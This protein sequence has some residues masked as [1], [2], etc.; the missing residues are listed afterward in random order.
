MKEES[1]CHILIAPVSK[2]RAIFPPFFP[3]D[4]VHALWQTKGNYI[5]S[6]R[7]AIKVPWISL[8]GICTV[9][10][11]IIKWQKDSK[12]YQCSLQLPQTRFRLNC[13]QYRRPSGAGSG[14]SESPPALGVPKDPN[15][16][17]SSSSWPT[18]PPGLIHTRW[19]DDAG[20]PTEN[21]LSDNPLSITHETGRV[22]PRD[23]NLSG[24]GEGDV[25]GG[26]IPNHLGLVGQLKPQVMQ[27][28]AVSTFRSG[29]HHPLCLSRG[30][31][32][33]LT[34]GNALTAGDNN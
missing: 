20:L 2:R 21:A 17:P 4:R 5:K 31:T 1:K 10:L 30:E 7:C 13:S 29:G 11:K 9:T 26:L 33:Q 8:K 28:D 22:Q 23:P 25:F 18:R 3:K 15:S 6:K 32:P 27:D 34:A 24:D 16:A 14:P 12:S 19:Q